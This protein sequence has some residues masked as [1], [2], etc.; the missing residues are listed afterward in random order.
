M[1]TRGGVYVA[2]VM[3]ACTEFQ[4]VCFQDYSRRAIVFDFVF[5]IIV[6]VAIICVHSISGWESPVLKQERNNVRLFI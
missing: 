6:Y 4:S 5:Q 2:S 3:L 1:I